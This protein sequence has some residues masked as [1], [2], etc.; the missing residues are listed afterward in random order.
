MKTDTLQYILVSQQP[1]YWL[2]IIS[3]AARTEVGLCQQHGKRKKPQEKLGLQ[4]EHWGDAQF[5]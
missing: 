1:G 5:L 2:D 4:R 3:C